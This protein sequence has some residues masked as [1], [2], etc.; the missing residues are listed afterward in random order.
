MSTEPILVLRRGT[1][2]MP[3]TDLSNE[4]R[5]RLPDHEIR[6]AETPVGER[7]LIADARIAV[8]MGIDEDLL[9]HAENLDLFACAYA[10]TG[11]LPMGSLEE[12]GVAVTNA[13]GV[14]GPNI[15]EGVVGSILA[16]YRGFFEGRDRQTNHE[17]RHYQTDEF[18]GATVTVVGLGAIG[19]AI[20]ERLAGFGVDTIG[21]RYTPEKGG[22]TDEVVGFEE[23]DLHGALSRTDVL[24]LA[25][26]LTD[27]TRGLIGEE[28]FVT[29][30]EDALLVNIARGPV[31]ETEA[32]VSA[33][34]RNK[35]RGAALDV[36]DP[37][38]LPGDHP[39]WDFGTVQITPHNAGHTPRYYERLADIVAGNVERI[40]AGEDE[41]ENQVA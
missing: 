20:V 7:E 24:V 39:L 25:C 32:L 11:H 35:L 22:P 29:L 40:D 31:V 13:A 18:M 14:H 27:T 1:H 36:T 12:A 16:F 41:L 9:S 4:L 17:W 34:R 28:E 38:P 6:V 5:D 26:P 21:V 10:G 2:G 8:G 23:A 15:A 33:L 19:Q 37:E 3:V 30:P